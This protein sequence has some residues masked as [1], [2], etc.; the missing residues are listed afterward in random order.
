MAAP[1]DALAERE[2]MDTQSDSFAVVKQGNLAEWLRCVICHEIHLAINAVFCRDCCTCMC[3]ADYA[4]WHDMQRQSNQRTS[5]P[6]CRACP[7]YPVPD[8]NYLFLFWRR[9]EDEIA[10]QCQHCSAVVPLRE[11]R[12]HRHQCPAFFV[13]FFCKRHEVGAEDMPESARIPADAAA[14]AKHLMAAH[15]VQIC[16]VEDVTSARRLEFHWQ[17]ATGKGGLAVLIGK[18][19]FACVAAVPTSAGH[20]PPGHLALWLSPK[21][22]KVATS[23]TVQASPLQ[24]AAQWGVDPQTGIYTLSTPYAPDKA[25]SATITMD[26]SVNCT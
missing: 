19:K 22:A 16:H 4:K 8:T 11:R 14:Y 1:N 20:S 25:V 12:Q 2:A 24:I 10:V 15:S 9:I 21:L 7:M 6:K 23:L 26:V 3:R 18:D 13:C 5:C 17:A